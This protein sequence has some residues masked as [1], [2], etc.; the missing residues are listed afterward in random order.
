MVTTG[1]QVNYTFV[2]I[3]WCPICKTTQRKRLGERGTK[4]IPE[5]QKKSSRELIKVTVYECVKCKHIYCSPCPDNNT[6]G[7]LYELKSGSYFNHL[8]E[9][10]LDSIQEIILKNTSTVGNLL[11][12]GCGNGRI[13][14]LMRDWNCEGLEPTE[15]F[16]LNASVFGKVHR[17]FDSITSNYDVITLLAV[18]EH[19]EDPIELL[20][21]AW[22]VANPKALLVIEVPN[23]HRPDAWLLDRLLVLS[24]RSWTVRTAPLQYPFHLSEFSIKSLQQA[25]KSTGWVVEKIWTLPGNVSYPIPTFLNRILNF[26]QKVLSPFGYGLN[27]NVIARKS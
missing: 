13:L 25:L 2:S 18:L 1:D 24:G 5:L 4:P 17:N 27:I 19:V 15:S 11:D 10:N 3:L 16:A 8:H 9:S 22:K 20:S 7:E 12:I 26:T 23:G 14:K 21:N 6:L